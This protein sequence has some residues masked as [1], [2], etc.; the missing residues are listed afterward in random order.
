MKQIL[1]LGVASLLAVG[2]TGVAE[3]QGITVNNYKYLQPQTVASEQIQKEGETP[4][5][6]LIWEDFSKFTAG[7]EEQPDSEIFGEEDWVDI[8][9]EYTLTPGW[10]ARGVHQSGGVAMVGE[11]YM[12]GIGFTGGIRTNVADLSANNGAV[13]VSFRAKSANAGG[14]EVAAVLNSS[15]TGYINQ[16][17][18]KITNEW[19]EYKLKLSG[20]VSD[21]FFEFFSVNYDWYLDDVKVVSEGIAS[22]TGLKVTSYKGTE[23]TFQWN[24]VDG[25]EKYKVQ[26]YYWDIDQKDYVYVVNEEE[27]TET[28]YT[29]TGLDM[30]DTYFA[31]VAAVSGEMSSAY[32]DS[33]TLAPTLAGPVG[34]APT[35]YDGKSFT[36][37]WEP[38]EDADYYL[39]NVYTYT[40]EGD[41][42]LPIYYIIDREVKE[43][44]FFVSNLPYDGYIYYFSVV[45]VRKDGEITKASKEIPALPI[46]ERPTAKP[47]TRVT[48]NSFV[49]NWEGVEYAN[50]YQVNVY[51]KHT[52]KA[53]ETYTLA[54]TDCDVFS[55]TGTIENPERLSGA[56]VFGSA[57]GAFDWYISMAAAI[58][59]GIGM[60]N[61][62]SDIMGNS[63]MYSQM[64]DL[65][66]SNG[67]AT[68]E[69]TLASPDA[70]TA[71]VS[72]AKLLD[73]NR[74]QPI[75]SFDIE[76]TKEMT[77]HTVEFTKGTD[78]C[79]VLVEMRNGSFLIFDDFKLTMDLQ[80][81][82]SIEIGI[83]NALLQ[84]PNATS[85]EFTRIDFNNDRISYDVLAAMVYPTLSS[86]LVSEL[87][88]RIE[89]E[90]ISSV[91]NTENVSASAYVEGG[92]L[93]VENPNAENVEVYNLSGVRI[94]ADN[95][96]AYNVN[97]N[98]DANGV[99]IVRVG[100]KAIKV[101]R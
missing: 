42:P 84:D 23:S 55:S 76:V 45:A 33:Y 44:S 27:T 91:E 87:S 63:Y 3:A 86:P 95:S 73:N 94:F 90:D 82:K 75:E 18:V 78:Y 41:F 51:R 1:F 70:T 28:S 68:F 83:T 17:R 4:A 54:D 40:K 92:V 10:Q 64:Y 34:I 43:T 66:G 77:K 12:F 67:K 88:N 101:V 26:V 93:Y 36:A 8:P 13:T 58:D 15:A 65:T 24:A 89:V 30:R 59:G 46:L 53:D 100:D 99:Y 47:A 72:I 19:Q 57:S 32:C 97:T 2:S 56:F 7:S 79:C 16:Q 20:G 5:G 98:L 80:A 21:S 81:E 85:A 22:P 60:D 69:F 96:G 35:D 11:Y 38:Y 50:T 14:D 62:Y 74:L 71:V 49:A 9:A 48:S 25:A 39:L 29:V 31:K 52:A 61:I 6:A 37:A